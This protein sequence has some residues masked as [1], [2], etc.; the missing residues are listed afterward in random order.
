MFANPL[1][2][3]CSIYKSRI[4]SLIENDGFDYAR[5]RG[6]V[7]KGTIFQYLGA[8]LGYYNMPKQAFKWVQKRIQK[9]MGKWRYVLLPFHS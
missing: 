4:I 9:N 2:S 1:G 3:Q 8:F 5:T 6:V 7:G